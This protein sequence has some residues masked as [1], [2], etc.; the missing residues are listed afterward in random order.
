MK[1]LLPLGLLLSSLCSVA[2]TDE[3][4][5]K[6]G[7][8]EAVA[9]NQLRRAGIAVNKIRGRG[10]IGAGIRTENDDVPAAVLKNLQYIKGLEEV[11]VFSNKMEE[12]LEAIADVPGLKIILIQAG[13]MS[14]MS[15]RSLRHLS[16]H[17]E[18]TQLS[19]KSDK[20]TDAGLIHLEP[21]KK[22]EKLKLIDTK[23]TKPGLEKL[24][25][26]L[27]KCVVELN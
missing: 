16:K 26:V 23:V 2:A 7:I 6:A 10:W 15:D 21:L 11:A 12:R 3:Q 1:N 18:V 9:I 22:L 17:T 24:Y 25:K 8:T 27:P 19:I 20:V 13:N 4:G 5:D 14:D